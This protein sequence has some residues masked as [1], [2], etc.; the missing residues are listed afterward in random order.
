MAVGLYQFD[1]STLTH[2]LSVVTSDGDSLKFQISHGS[3]RTIER[4][5]ASLSKAIWEHRGALTRLPYKTLFEYFF[6]PP[7]TQLRHWGYICITR[8]VKKYIK[9]C[10]VSVPV[11]IPLD[12]II[13][14]KVSIF[15]DKILYWVIR[16]WQE[17]VL[18]FFLSM[19][20][21]NK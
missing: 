15:N 3:T 8:P 13:E 18:W 11:V 14:Y 9:R 21:K 17:R 20:Y 6:R 2:W 10:A 5:R 12:K 7:S 16:I 4:T 19:E 1:C